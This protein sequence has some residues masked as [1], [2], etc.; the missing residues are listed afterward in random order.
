MQLSLSLH[1]A[2]LAVQVTLRLYSTL[3]KWH[4]SGARGST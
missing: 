4:M 2:S 1:A 3:M